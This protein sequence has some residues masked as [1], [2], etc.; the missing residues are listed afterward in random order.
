MCGIAGLL[1]P[2]GQAD[3]AARASAMAGRLRHRGPDSGDVWSDPEAGIALG[4]RR[5]AV[6][7][8]SEAGHQP[9]TSSCGRLVLSYNGEIYNGPE[10]RAELEALGRRFR[11]HSDTEVIAE[12]VAEWG[13]DALLPRLI[14][15]FTFALWDR[16][17]RSLALVRDRFGI[18]PLY[19]GQDQGCFRFGSELR[20]LS[21]EPGFDRR[22]DRDAITAYLRFGYVPAPQSIYRGARK[23][24]PGHVL[25]IGPGGA[26]EIRAWWR[27]ADLVRA[28]R[29]APFT[30]DEDAAVEALEP[31][32]REA[33]GQRMVADVP[34]GVFLSGGIDSSTVAALMQAQSGVPVKTFTIGF[35]Q[36]G[37]DEAAHAA[38]I[39]AHLGTEHRQEILTAE[40]ALAVIPK[41]AQISDE[42]FADPSIIPTWLVSRMTRRDVTVALSGDGGD[43]MFGGYNRYIEAMGRLRR[44]WSLPAPARRALAG[45]VRAVPGRWWPWVAPQL[46]E[47]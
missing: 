20:A 19:W 39:A 15:M 14:G 13:L 2:G 41:L 42:P 24:Q 10:L 38:R 27:L 23:L 47:A 12:G 33:V 29:E 18:K 37:Y 22:V 7:D 3:L 17:A 25:E 16:Q 32:L 34:L 43:E 36:P 46:P 9:M 26:P 21:A 8:L 40:A 30:E 28:G 1:D 35:D 31:L 5:L 44:L 6:I 4:H 11:G 45:A